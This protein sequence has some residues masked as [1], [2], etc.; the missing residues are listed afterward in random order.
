MHEPFKLSTPK[1]LPIEEGVSDEGLTWS[2][3][4]NLE[5]EYAFKHKTGVYRLKMLEVERVV[6]QARE[7][8][9]AAAA[10]AKAVR[11]RSTAPCKISR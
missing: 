11:S 9:A 1:K 2:E 6:R 10:A 7:E 3:R 8:E 5:L 4:R